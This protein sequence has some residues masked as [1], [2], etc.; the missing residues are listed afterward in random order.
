MSEIQKAEFENL[1]KVWRSF[2]LGLVF[3]L[4]LQDNFVEK[5]QSEDK[6]TFFSMENYER[7]FF[8]L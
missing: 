5:N 7:I 6:I 4:I 3:I 8:S 2:C 1:Y